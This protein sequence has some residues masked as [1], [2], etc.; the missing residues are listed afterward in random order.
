MVRFFSIAISFLFVR[1]A[2]GQTDT[3]SA[4]DTVTSDSN[5][6]YEFAEIMPEYPGG[7]DALMTYINLNKKIPGDVEVYGTVYI[8]FVVE[9]DGSISTIEIMRGIQG[10]EY[11]SKEAIRL[12]K[13]MPKW[14]PGK[15]ASG[16]VRSR[17]RIPVKFR[18]Y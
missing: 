2:Y 15:F 7:S 3:L 5:K 14:T 12:V 16:P 8:S 11:C 6:I 4:K 9:K 1:S 17:Y 13:G 10:C 18:S